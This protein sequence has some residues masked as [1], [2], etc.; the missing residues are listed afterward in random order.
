MEHLYRFALRSSVQH[1]EHQP[2]VEV[3]HHV[4]SAPVAVRPVERA[5]LL[6]VAQIVPDVL[7]VGVVD[8]E[9]VLIGVAEE[10][11]ER[12]VVLVA[13][14]LADHRAVGV[15]AR[16]DE[17]AESD[18]DVVRPE[19]AALS[20]VVAEGGAADLRELGFCE[21]V[22]GAGAFGVAAEILRHAVK[23][24]DA[25]EHRLAAIHHRAVVAAVVAAGLHP[26]PVVDAGEVALHLIDGDGSAVADRVGR[27]ERRG[28]APDGFERIVFS[29]EGTDQI[30]HQKVV[31]D[32]VT[33]VAEDADVAGILRRDGEGV[34]VLRSG[35]GFAERAPE[36]V[37]AV[38]R[39]ERNPGAVE[40][41]HVVA[42]LLR[43]P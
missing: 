11:V 26:R 32:A 36:A 23:R 4:A 25:A 5:L 9:P 18:V 33:A 14:R 43:Q 40:A 27:S 10:G 42:E 37:V 21:V 31:A 13:R 2:G 1:Q 3:P 28:I 20:S 19:R 24:G 34:E 16:R 41:A 29:S 6:I 15:G 22:G 8:V 35:I 7:R 30:E 12:A 39:K 38:T 17:F